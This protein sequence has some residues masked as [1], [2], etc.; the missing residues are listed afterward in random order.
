MISKTDLPI[1][2][3]NLFLH[4]P[5]FCSIIFSCSVTC[6][7]SAF[8]YAFKIQLSLNPTHPFSCHPFFH[9]FIKICKN[10]I[11]ISVLCFFRPINSAS[12]A[13]LHLSLDPIPPLKRPFTNDV[14]ASRAKCTQLEFSTVYFSYFLKCFLLLPSMFY[15]NPVYSCLPIS[16][17]DS[18]LCQTLEVLVFIY[19]FCTLPR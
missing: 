7:L 4:L 12:S 16:L 2:L 19:S 13:R 6:I 3:W 14:H 5:L 17:S 8:K 1:V 18:P 11:Y 9:A 10:K 15:T